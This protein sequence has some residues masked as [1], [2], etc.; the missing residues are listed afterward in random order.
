MVAPTGAGKTIIAAGIVKMAM[1]K[2]K[3]VVFIANR[4]ELV[5]QTV[6]SFERVGIKCGILQ[7]MNTWNANSQVVVAS[8]QTM[9]RRKAKDYDLIIIDECHGTAASKA[10]HSLMYRNTNVPIIGLTAT[11]WSKGMARKHK[12]LQNEPL[13]QDVVIAATIPELIE[14]GFL[15]DCDIYAPGEPDLTGVKVVSG[16]YD[17]TQL[18]AATDKATLI[19]DIV[20]TWI[21]LG[22]GEQTVVFAVNVAHS[23]HITQEFQNHGFDARHVDGYM[24]QE[25]RTPIIE[26]FRRGEFQILSNCSM[27]SEGFDVP[28]TSCCVLARPTK[29]LIRFIQMVGRVL[30]PH[31]GKDRAIILDHSGVVKRLG[32]PT[33]EIPYVLD[34][35]RPK[36]K[37]EAQENLPIV[38]PSCSAVR[39]RSIRKCPVCQFEPKP[40]PSGQE[41]EEGELVQLSKKATKY[42]MEDKQ[43]IYSALLGHAKLKGFKPGFAY[44]Q[45]KEMMGH[46]PSN[47]MPTREGPM[48]S[49]VEGWLKHKAIKW[50]K[51]QEKNFMRR[52]A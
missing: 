8:I 43:R 50:A 39:P 40:V 26:A 13:W 47:K 44:H 27:L 22:G 17:K 38:C 48:C 23:R 49:E 14:A 33:A 2:G 18:A 16:D 51:S 52:A 24:T 35:G 36:E 12:E 9:I 6:E 30:R 28:S 21:K 4:I 42:S 31:E 41:F 5:K 10:Y 3:R 32:W 11:P 25:E 7:G 19:G 45:F 1:E 29:S 46:Y 15:V 37:G 20:K 34:D